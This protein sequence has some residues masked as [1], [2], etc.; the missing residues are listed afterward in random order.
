MLDW[1]GDEVYINFNHPAFREL[2]SSTVFET[3]EPKMNQHKWHKEIKAWADGAEIEFQLR[4]HNLWNSCKDY[5]PFW[6]VDTSYRIKP[7]KPRV[8]AVIVLYSPH[9]KA[10][11][12]T[13]E[14]IE[15]LSAAGVDYDV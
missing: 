12:L 10:I 14:V 6:A 5:E 1:K 9:Y 3:E 2:L 15:A 8:G 4:P 7:S 13:P 11:E